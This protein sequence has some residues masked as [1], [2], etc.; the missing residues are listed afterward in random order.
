MGCIFW[1]L[2]E[3]SKLR[4]VAHPKLDNFAIV[5]HAGG[6]GVMLTDALSSCRVLPSTTP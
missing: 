6:P 5:T 4:E 3:D 1:V 2:E